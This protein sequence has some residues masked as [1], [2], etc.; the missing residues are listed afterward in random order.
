[1]VLIA[2]YC[3]LVFC[4][5]PS[6]T[7]NRTS[8]AGESRP[9]SSAPATDSSPSQSPS[10]NEASQSYSQGRTSNKSALDR[11]GTG[12]DAD[13]SKAVDEL[14]ETR[15]LEAVPELSNILLTD[16]A[17]ALR[18]HSATSL[19][20]IADPSTVPALTTALMKDPV[21]SVSV[22]AAE[23]LGRIGGTEA[24][25]ALLQESTPGKPIE[26]RSAAVRAL[27]SFKSEESNHAL[28]TYSH[29]PSP[30]VR[31]AAVDGLVKQQTPEAAAAVVE[32]LG[33]Q[34]PN[35]SQKAAWGLGELRDKA[36]IPALVE[37][38][39][40]RSPAAVRQVS[41]FAL[42]RI[43]DPSAAS[44]LSRLALDSSDDVSVRA[45]AIQGLGMLGKADV[46]S[47]F[48]EIFRGNQSILQNLAA[49]YTC[50]LRIGEAAS[51]MTELLSNA[52]GEQK[53]SLIS[54]MGFWPEQF[55]DRLANLA[56]DNKE[57][58]ETR[59]LA[60][61]ALYELPESAK[62]KWAEKLAWSL[63][64]ADQVDLQLAM[65]AFV[66]DESNPSITSALKK[67]SATPGVNSMVK[68]EVEE[69]LSRSR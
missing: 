64:A 57:D 35:V 1:M 5:Q 20:Y 12:I 45:A 53:K 6:P 4:Q 27:G 68:S 34:D 39:Q 13:R 40:S 38:L 65:I 43:G 14:G 52:G 67:F 26:V 66:A 11:A 54:A 18:K 49:F 33:D 3:P 10:W 62:T 29:D 28:R 63:S 25:V 56:T 44:V 8:S 46:G 9:Q 31:Y 30:E 51:Q 19:G 22:S 60:L 7:A 50:Q 48:R 32:V 21:T 36:S 16:R 15:S 69:V 37:K 17:A 61:A 55:A 23:S 59:S 41:A 42:G 24:Q 58:S 47:T 2:V